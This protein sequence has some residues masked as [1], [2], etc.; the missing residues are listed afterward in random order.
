MYTHLFTESSLEIDI[1]F[2]IDILICFR[3]SI[4]DVDGKEVTDTKLIAESYFKGTFFV[5]LIAG[6]LHHFYPP[7]SYLRADL[8]KPWPS[9]DQ[10]VRGKLDE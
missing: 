9:E 3:T 5:D 10:P 1:A 4:Y 8:K 7:S 6:S 2:I